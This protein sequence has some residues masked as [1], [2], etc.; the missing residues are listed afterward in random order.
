MHAKVEQWREQD[1]PCNAED[2]VGTLLVMDRR[3]DVGTAVGAQGSLGSLMMEHCRSELS[4]P[5]NFGQTQT[6]PQPAGESSTDGKGKSRA[7][8]QDKE[9]PKAPGIL[10]LSDRDNPAFQSVRF[11]PAMTGILK[12][13]SEYYSVQARRT[14]YPS[15]TRV[16]ELGGMSMSNAEL[17]ADSVDWAELKPHQIHQ[18]AK[19]ILLDRYIRE[20]SLVRQ[21]MTAV[22][23]MVE[24][25][26]VL[27]EVYGLDGRH[28]AAP[29]KWLQL[30]HQSLLV[31]GSWSNDETWDDSEAAVFGRSP[32]SW[33]PGYGYEFNG[34]GRLMAHEDLLLQV[35]D[36]DSEFAGIRKVAREAT[37]LLYASC[38]GVDPN[39]LA[40]I[41][42]LDRV[43]STSWILFL[44]HA[45]AA[46]LVKSVD[47]R[48]REEELRSKP[49]RDQQDWDNVALSRLYQSSIPT[50]MREVGE[51]GLSRFEIEMRNAVVSHRWQPRLKRVCQEIMSGGDVSD[52]AP[53]VTDSRGRTQAEG[54]RTKQTAAGARGPSVSR[55]SREHAER[56]HAGLII[57]VVGGFTNEELQM[58]HELA[59]TYQ[60]NVYIGGTGVYTNGSFVKE[61]KK[62]PVDQRDSATS[63]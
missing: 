23:Q 63:Y 30:Y 19:P 15:V 35:L 26:E 46:M 2:G 59:A 60:T 32:A 43:E 9:A 10:D 49:W 34:S 62:I 25:S 18:S 28:E 38:K 22:T 55:W 61:L 20:K 16:D 6:I 4:D 39:T 27:Q 11:L 17:V 57:F 7:G 37:L 58:A 44:E 54:R 13:T 53:A 31:G 3:Y 12:L 5:L 29:M 40:R 36:P 21:E 45:D 42:D 14:R 52:G 51:V 41:R 47:Y 50:W 33:T 1:D 56:S 8:G 48:V 24:I